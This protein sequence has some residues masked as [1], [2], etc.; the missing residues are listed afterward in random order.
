MIEKLYLYV[1][2]STLPYRNIAAEMVMLEHL[3]PRCGIFYLWQNRRTVVIGRNQNAWKECRVG[4]LESSG[5][6]LARRLS[7][8]G[9][10]FHDLGNLCFT[11]MLPHED[12]DV[13]RQTGILLDAL[14]RLNL[15]GNAVMKG[16]NDLEIDGKKFSGHAYY[17]GKAS[18][19][20][21]GTFLV[22][23]DLALAQ[24]YLSPPPEKIT[25]KGVES[26]KSRMTNLCE[27]NRSLTVD[28]L[29]GALIES[30]ENAYGCAGE[31]LDEGFFDQTEIAALEARFA[32]PEWKYGLSPL[33]SVEQTARFDWGGVDLH[34]D[35]IE[36]NIAHLTVY[37]D[38]LDEMFILD[39]PRC[40]NGEPFRS[41]AALLEKIDGLYQKRLQRLGNSKE[42]T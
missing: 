14:K 6:F 23:A 17:R 9:A 1:S 20:H 40:L 35:V 3:P 38:A 29:S 30:V 39:L 10:V 37:S 42:I 13:G 16:R 5:G 33:C 36:G 34:F 8:G 12:Y 11:F 4:E 19:M 27:F 25:S 31:L 2:G 18:A 21:H 41:S 28:M 7:G 15:N 22:N 26:V 32:A 24:Q